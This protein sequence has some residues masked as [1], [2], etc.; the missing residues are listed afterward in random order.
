MRSATILGEES[1]CSHIVGLGDVLM[2]LNYQRKCG[3]YGFIGID[4]TICIELDIKGTCDVQ[5]HAN[6]EI[7]TKFQ[8]YSLVIDMMV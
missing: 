4:L 8:A 6:A 3:N 5:T 2:D 7:G 1:Q